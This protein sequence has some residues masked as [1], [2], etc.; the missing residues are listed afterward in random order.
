MSSRARDPFG[1][2]FPWDAADTASHG[3]GLSVMASEYDALTGTAT[4]RAFAARWLG[5]VLGANAWGSSFIIGDGTTFPDC[6]QHQVANI[7][8]SLDGSAPVLAGAV[9]EGPAGEASS[10]RLAGMRACPLKATTRSRALTQA[11]STGT[12]FSRTRTPSPRSI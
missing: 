9:V 5:N 11:R 2:G 10:G 12:T 8:G 3:D 4:Y 7:V 6:P 1:F